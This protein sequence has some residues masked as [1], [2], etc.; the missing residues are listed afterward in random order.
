MNW[1]QF[2][3]NGMMRHKTNNIFWL[4]PHFLNWMGGHK[5]IYEIVR[6]LSKRYDVM[7]VADVFSEDSKYKFNKLGLQTITLSGISTNKIVYWVLLP[8]Y[9][10]KDAFL[11]K[12]HTNSNDILITSMFPMN[13]VATLLGV[14]H[15]QLCYEPFAFF[16]DD[17][18]ISGFPKIQKIFIKISKFFYSWMDVVSTRRA[19]VVLTISEF[20]RKW[21]KRIYGINSLVVYEGVDTNFFKVTVNNSLS[22]KYGGCNIIFHSTDFTR[23]KGTELLVKSMPYIK[24]EFPNIKLLISTTLSNIE[25]QS[26]YLSF[27]EKNTFLESI[28]FLG[29]LNFKMIPDYLSLADVVVQPS[30]GQS[31]NLTIKEAMACGTPVV[32]SLEGREQFLDNTAGYLVDPMKTGELADRIIKILKDRRLAKKM[33]ING[34]KIIKEKFS[35]EAVSSKIEGAILLINK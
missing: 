6:R 13:V 17:N 28:E 14:K 31:M 21:I 11:L 24:K 19:L 2:L 34:A 3:I 5:Y 4:H 8:F 23:I 10:I 1:D 33:G 22:K 15:I 30:I 29:F 26:K 16:Y 27:A 7:I 9:I 35:W 32:T 20:N 12:K 18:F 25:Q